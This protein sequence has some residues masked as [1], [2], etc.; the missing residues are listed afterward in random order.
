[1]E[2]EDL[3]P[4]IKAE[5][6]DEDPIPLRITSKSKR[7]LRANETAATGSIGSATWKTR[8]VLLTIAGLVVLLLIVGSFV[9]GIFL[10]KKIVHD[11]ASG[12]SSCGKCNNA[13]GT[14]PVLTPS[15]G[16]GSAY[17]GGT[18]PGSAYDMVYNWGATV[19]VRGQPMRVVDWLNTNMT[20]ENMM[21]NLK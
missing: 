16:N 3:E 5:D 21:N 4:F 17:A 15:S 2:E 14:Q 20:A 7:R 11:H 13:G 6:E 19:N 1:M 10:G 8:L 9:G 18:Q 12:S